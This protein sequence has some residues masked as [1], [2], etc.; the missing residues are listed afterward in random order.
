MTES[1][2]QQARS[3]TWCGNHLT[4]I[5]A[6]TPEGV[7]GH[8]GGMPWHLGSDLRRFKALT[9]GGILIMGRKTYDSIG[10]PLPG[11]QTIVVTRDRH[12]SA[13]GVR[14]V[15]SPQQA[16][17]QVADRVAFVVGGAEIYRQLIPY[18]DCLMLTRV[19]ARLPGDTFLELDLSGF[20]IAERLECPVSASDQYPT[21]FLVYRRTVAGDYA[22]GERKI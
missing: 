20:E 14:V 16:L 13:A 7:I 19:L 8:D 1:D 10:R 2:C 11:R 18:C 5:V 6:M 3:A 17:D 4:A 9:M 21:E 22:A 12:W 15:A